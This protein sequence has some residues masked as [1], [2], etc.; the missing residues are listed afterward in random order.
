MGLFPS[1]INKFKTLT[2]AGDFQVC[3][4]NTEGCGHEPLEPLPYQV[5]LGGHSLGGCR[6]PGA[7]TT[8]LALRLHSTGSVPGCGCVRRGGFHRGGCGCIRCVLLRARWRWWLVRVVW[9][10]V[11]CV[12]GGW[13]C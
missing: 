11:W 5:V 4:G 9:V 1:T 8:V 2:S 3:A 6:P 12:W 10:G 7:V 13:A